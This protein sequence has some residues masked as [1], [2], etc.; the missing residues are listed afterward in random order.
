MIKLHDNYKKVN[1]NFKYK[2]LTLTI[3]NCILD[4]PLSLPVKYGKEFSLEQK[5]WDI[6]TEYLLGA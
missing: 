1:K 3:G 5:Y 4:I 6:A 2:Y